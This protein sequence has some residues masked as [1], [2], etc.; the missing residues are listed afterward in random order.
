[1]VDIMRFMW[2]AKDEAPSKE[3]LQAVARVLFLEPR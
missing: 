2:F 3:D 1:M